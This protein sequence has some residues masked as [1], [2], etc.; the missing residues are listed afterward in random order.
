MKKDKRFDC[1]QMKW[2]IQQQIDEEFS[3]LPDK[4]AY[5]VKFEKILKNNI[6]GEFLDRFYAARHRVPSA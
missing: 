1:V 6:L 4:E 2:E 5:K 3:G